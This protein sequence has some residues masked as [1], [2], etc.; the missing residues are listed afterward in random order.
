[1]TNFHGLS[2]YGLRFLLE[3]ARPLPARGYHGSWL[4]GLL[5][6][7]LFRGVCLYS[8]PHCSECALRG[9]CAYPQIF[10][11]HLL[12][13]QQRLP[14][15]LLHDWQVK[16]HSRQV[17]VVLIL[18]ANA[19]RYAETW[20]TQVAT[21]ITNLE[22]GGGGAGRLLQVTD[23]ATAEVIFGEGRFK[24]QVTL[25]PLNFLPTRRS[26]ISIR[27]L[28]P[29][30]SKHQHQDP[31]LAPLR[32]RL[33]RL[34]NDYGNGDQLSL[35]TTLWRINQLQLRNTVIPRGIE[36]PRHIRG[37]IGTIELSEVTKQ[38]ALWLAV[39]QYVHAGG[40]T[41]LGFG[42]FKIEY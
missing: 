9:Q 1:M 3:T 7:A 6:H 15:Y 36:Q 23:L 11:P 5:G 30:V 21:Q 31:L 24:P 33:Q 37:R 20:I 42:R 28:T 22:M 25:T 17:G 40:E 26:T 10:K 18:V 35:E 32:T 34:V 29:L 19:V 38:G 8:E 2:C 13:S 41:S 39:G 4:R 14:S 27:F 16:T 12:P